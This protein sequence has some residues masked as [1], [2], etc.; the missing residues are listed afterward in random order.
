MTCH[1]HVMEGSSQQKSLANT[2]GLNSRCNYRCH[3]ASLE[4]PD[5]LRSHHVT[6]W[7]AIQIQTTAHQHPMILDLSPS[8]GSQRRCLG[9]EEIQLALRDVHVLNG[10]PEGVPEQWA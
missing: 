6:N 5:T 9:N 3:S 4:N 1:T 7:P 10:A 8:I 2:L